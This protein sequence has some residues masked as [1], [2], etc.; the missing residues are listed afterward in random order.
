MCT[1]ERRVVY[2]S[3]MDWVEDNEE[4]MYKK[5][6][7]PL[8]K[9]YYDSGIRGGHDGVDWLVLR[10][11]IESVKRGTNTPIDVYDTVSWMAIAPLSEMSIAKGGAPV[12]VPDFTKGKWIHREP[13]VEGKYCLD[14]VCVDEDTK[15]V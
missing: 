10:A 6:D 12:E 2:F 11:F 5:Y 3:G 15:I 8:Q 13:I 7:H 9:E 4:E 14:K 1:E